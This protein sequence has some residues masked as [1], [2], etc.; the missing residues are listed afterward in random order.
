MQKGSFPSSE[1]AF[2]LKIK[3]EDEFTGSPTLRSGVTT[4]GITILDVNDNYPVFNPTLYSVTVLETA[5]TGGT[6]ATVTV[7]DDDAG[8]LVC[9]CV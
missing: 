9:V 1:H 7:T 3:A 2:F 5:P 6:V 8:S 4:V